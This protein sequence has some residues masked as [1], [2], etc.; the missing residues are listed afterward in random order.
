[1][2]DL[3]LY[4]DEVLACH[5][6]AA[7]REAADSLA[8]GATP[9]IFARPL[10][11]PLNCRLARA[12]EAIIVHSDWSRER[13]EK[14]APGVPV[15]RINHHITSDAAA[16]WARNTETQPARDARDASA[17]VRIA[18]FGLITPDKGVERALR[19]L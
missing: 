5:G 14:I 19:A 16:G 8:R 15:R 1:R 2:G 11:F 4:L 3:R 13:F 17:P 12:S 18:S 6:E 7:R 9:A 10:D